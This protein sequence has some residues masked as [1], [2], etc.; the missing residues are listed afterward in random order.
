MSFIVWKK[1]PGK[2]SAL[3]VMLAL[4]DWSNDN[5]RAYGKMSSLGRKARMSERNAQLIVNSLEAQGWVKVV[6]HAVPGWAN[7]FQL[8]KKKLLSLRDIVSKEDEDQLPRVKSFH[9]SKQDKLR[10]PP[11]GEK[12]GNSRVKNPSHKGEIVEKNRENF[13]PHH[14]MTHDMT[15]DGRHEHATT[16]VENSGEESSQKA[17]EFATNNH[18]EQQKVFSSNF[19][20]RIT[21]I[22]TDEGGGFSA[23]EL[24]AGYLLVSKNPERKR[25]G[26]G[27]SD[28]E[29]AERLCQDIPFSLEAFLWLIEVQIPWANQTPGSLKYFEKGIRQLWVR[30]MDAVI[31]GT[32]D[33]N[34]PFSESAELIQEVVRREVEIWY[35]AKGPQ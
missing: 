24:V 13:S 15:E 2:G 18:P 28:I 21:L 27:K 31:D 23:R 19:A 12:R 5:G 20:R 25:V 35:H 7:D 1:F 3:V 26:E 14:V 34:I 33:L 4:A 32:R 29:T 17:F 10:F 6:R 30:C 16:T 11:K 9:P 8:S 22:A